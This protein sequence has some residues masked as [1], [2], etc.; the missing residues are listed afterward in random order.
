[1]V[2]TAAQLKARFAEFASVE[3]ALVSEWLGVAARQMN[4]DRWGNKLNDGQM[5]LA[6]HMMKLGRIGSEAAPT[7]ARGPIVSET[8]GAV[9]RSYAVDAAS[10]SS[11]SF[12]STFYGQQY[13]ALRRGLFRSPVVA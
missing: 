12:G 1:M 3:D 9:S 5:F 13:E 2:A 11:S 4:P 6:A 7:A 8:V 10:M